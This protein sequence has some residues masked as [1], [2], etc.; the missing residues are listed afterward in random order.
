MIKVLK[1]ITHFGVG[2]TE[3]QFVYITKGL[4]RAHF[5]VRVGC[6]ARVGTFM[7]EVEAAGVPITEY[8][9]NSLCSA[10][11]LRRQVEL[12][13]DIRRHGIHVI[14]SYGFYPNVFTIPPA[15]LGTKCITIASVRDMGSFSNCHAMRRRT[16]AVVCRFA[17]CVLANSNAVREWLIGQGL[18]RCDIRVIPNGIAIPNARDPREGFPIREQLHIDRNAPVIAVIGRLMR[19]KGLEFFLEA[20]CAIAGRFP[21]VRFLIVGGACVEPRYRIELE[22]RAAD[23][24]LAGRVIF[25][26]ERTDVLQIVREVNISVQPSLTESFSNSLLESMANGL[27]VIATNVGGNPELVDDGLNG[28]LVP[29]R[30]PPA[31]ARAM[32]QLLES[33]R[34]SRRMGQAAREK[35]MR[36]Y[37]MQTV[38]SRTEKLYATLVGIRQKSL[39]ARARA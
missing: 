34:L 17:D 23:L 25:T 29:P 27:P 13:R 20:A 19:T 6:M 3:R 15:A 12:A 1:F 18:G 8:K 35:V 37:S 14:H 21:S 31:L 22:R 5:D 16:Q 9:T 24:N 4:D 30:D 39:Y 10:M 38:L 28:I 11:T 36:E 26:G 7:N 2:G 33:E 32:T